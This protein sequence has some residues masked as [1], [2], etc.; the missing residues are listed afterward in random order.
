MFV[1]VEV[2][3]TPLWENPMFILAL[4]LI[5]IVVIFALALFVGMWLTRRNLS[6]AR[7]YRDIN[8][9]I[10]EERAYMQ[11]DLFDAAADITRISAMHNLHERRRR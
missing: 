2:A 10:Q 7:R 11:N 8:R 9:L 6:E 3:A 1:E 5:G 4:A